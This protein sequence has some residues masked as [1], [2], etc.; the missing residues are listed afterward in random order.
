MIVLGHVTG[1]NPARW[2]DNI[3]HLAPGEA[4][5]EHFAAMK[6]ERVPDFVRN[7]RAER[8]RNGAIYVPAYVLEYCILTATRA[9]EA[10]GCRW[11]EIDR[12]AKVWR[13]PKDRMKAGRTFEAPLSEA[14]MAII[15]EMEKI[16]VE[17][18]PFVFPGYSRSVPIAGVSLARLLRRMGET[19]T[20]H[21]FRSAFRDWAGNETPTPRDVCEAALAHKVGDATER[22]YRRQD[23]L[24][25]RRV[26]MGLWAQYLSGSP[27][28]AAADNAVPFKAQ[29]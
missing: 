12:D 19:C 25:K 15:D 18:C 8:E 17:G 21:G 27:T 10:L 22:S 1:L 3:E 29:A 28:D 4:E 13:L 11:E 14:A 9:G 20:V 23:G 2:K 24:A 7:L 5:R 16:K 6:Y 26:L